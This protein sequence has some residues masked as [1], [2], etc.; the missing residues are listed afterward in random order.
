MPHAPQIAALSIQA[1]P[2]IGGAVPA[3]AAAGSLGRRLA[4]E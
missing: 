3:D 1:V 4:R 2:A